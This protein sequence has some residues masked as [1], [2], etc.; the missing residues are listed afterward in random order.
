MKKNLLQMYGGVV[1]WQRT[2]DNYELR[3]TNYEL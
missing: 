3:I 1:V 2:K